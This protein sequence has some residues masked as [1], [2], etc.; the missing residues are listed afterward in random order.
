MHWKYVNFDN[1]CKAKNHLKPLWIN[2]LACGKHFY[3]L[4]Q[5]FRLLW[6]RKEQFFDEKGIICHFG[7]L[8]ISIIYS[9]NRQK[10]IIDWLKC[11]FFELQWDSEIQTICKPTSFWSLEIQ[12]SPDFSSRK[13]KKERTGQESGSTIYGPQQLTFENCLKL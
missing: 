9:M 10:I 2:N 13:L 1:N 4:K 5:N 3:I 12:T 7:H 6:V 11:C 8:V